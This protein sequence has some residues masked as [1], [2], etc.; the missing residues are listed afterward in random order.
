MN[1]VLALVIG[2]LA[3]L[4]LSGILS[5]LLIAALPR[6]YR[7]AGAVWATTAV[8]VA[9]SVWAALRASEPR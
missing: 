1:R 2:L 4:V 9:L 6:D 8:I 3:G 7:G 5:A